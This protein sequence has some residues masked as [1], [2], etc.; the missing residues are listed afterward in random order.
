MTTQLLND[1][2][3]PVA[4]SVEIRV[5]SLTTADHVIPALA[6]TFIGHDDQTTHVMFAG[7][8]NDLQAF[9]KLVKKAVEETVIQASLI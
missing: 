7:E 2:P 4:T 5:A 8:P 1:Q 3:L 6:F 9:L